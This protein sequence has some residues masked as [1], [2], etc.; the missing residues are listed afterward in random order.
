MRLS[1]ARMRRPRLVVVRP[2]R[3]MIVSWLT[4]G[5]PRQFWVKKANDNYPTKFNYAYD[6]KTKRMTPESVKEFI[7]HQR[8]WNTY[9]ERC[10]AVVDKAVRLAER[11]PAEMQERLDA[12]RGYQKYLSETIPQARR[13]L[14]AFRN[15]IK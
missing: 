11:Y 7:A 10:K 14:E 9:T 12:L 2:M 8:D 3:W 13:E 5:R 15:A 4:S 6:A 1:F